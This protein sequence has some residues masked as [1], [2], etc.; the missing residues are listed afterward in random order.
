MKNRQAQFLRIPFIYK[1]RSSGFHLDAKL[2]ELLRRQ[3]GDQL[4]TWVQ[5]Q[6]DAIVAEKSG[7]S[8]LELHRRL[9]LTIVQANP[10]ASAASNCGR[11]YGV[12]RNLPQCLLKT[13]FLANAPERV[14][15]LGG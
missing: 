12:Q 5:R 9:N 1:G 11:C 3:V 8:W 7:I 6:A 10:S 4:N 15:L 14:C 2:A 13:T